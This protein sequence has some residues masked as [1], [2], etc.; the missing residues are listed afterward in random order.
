MPVDTQI[1][2]FVALISVVV[3][4]L[5]N[6][7]PPASET[8]TRKSLMGDVL[9]VHGRHVIGCVLKTGNMQPVCVPRLDRLE[10]VTGLFSS[11]GWCRGLRIKLVGGRLWAQDL[12]EEGKEER[13]R[14]GLA[15]LRAWRCGN[16][17]PEG[18]ALIDRGANMKARQWH[19][20][21]ASRSGNWTHRGADVG[22]LNDEGR[23]PRQP[24]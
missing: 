9:A 18:S 16:A 22:L 17:I 8:S 5:L 13:G 3:I 12:V 20:Q 11:A 15:S 4:L 1:K 19:H 14:E 21:I 7:L 10:R 24:S 2:A 23:T 6:G